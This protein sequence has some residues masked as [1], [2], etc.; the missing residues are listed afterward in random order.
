MSANAAVRR[1]H[2]DWLS[3]LQR[4]GPFL[5]VPVLVRTWPAGLD[6]VPR[7]LMDELR[8][9]FEEWREDPAARHQ[10]WITFVLEELLDWDGR[11]VQGPDLPARL[12]LPVPERDQVLR[13]DFGFRGEG[14][15]YLLLGTVHPPGTNLAVRLPGER[16][17]A[18]PTDRLALLL[19][20]HRVPLGLATD[21]RWWA[22]VWAAPETT[23]VAIWD[24]ALWLEE[25]D[26]LAAFRCLLERRRF[27]GVPEAQTLPRLL[28][29]GLEAQEEITETLGRQVRQAV[30][31]LV[32]AIGRAG[33]E[34]GPARELL[35]EISAQEIYRA[36]VTVMMRLVFLLFAEERLLLPADDDLYR[37]SYSAGQLVDELRAA[38]NDA[39]S[40]DVLEHRTTAWHRLLS[41]F[42]AVHRG[43]AH[44]RLRIPAYGGGVFDPDRYPWLEGRRSAE[45]PPAGA[46]VLPIDDRT[47]LHALEA[48]QFVTVGGERRRLTFRTLDVEQIGYVYEGLLGYDAVRAPEPVAGLI[49]R[50]GEEPEV[51]VRELEARGSDPVWLAEVTGLSQGRIARALALAEADPHRTELLL[52]A[53]CAGD[54]GL[55]ARLRP[56]AGLLRQ[57]LR[58]LPVVVPAGGLYVTASRRRRQSG[59]HYTPRELAERVV[60]GALEPLVYAPGP[61]E[62]KDRSAWRLRPSREILGLR[63]VD[64]AM[65]SGAFLVAAC[66][67]L[68]DR[69]VE[70]WTVEGN[71]LARRPAGTE[72]LDPESDP[73]VIEARRRVIERCLYGGDINEMAVEMAKLS[74]WL[75]SLSRE[76][77]FSFLDDRLVCGD[78]LLGL[79]SLEQLRTL[80]LDPARA[81]RRAGGMSESGFDLWGAVSRALGEAEGI[82]RE[83]AE[84]PLRDVR[85]AAY[86]ARLLAQAEATERPLA[87]IADAMVGAALACGEEAER[88]L[89]EVAA[90]AARALREADPGERERRLRAMA[91][92]AAARLEAGRPEGAFPRRPTHWPLVFPEVFER[93]GF[94]AVVGNP[95]FLGG[96][97][98]TGAFGVP[99]RE[100]LVRWV[101]RGK[102]GSADLVAYFLLV[103]HAILSPNGQAGLIATN[104]LAQGDTREVGLDR[105]VAD[106]V[107]I[108]AA[109][110]SAKWPT[111]SAN[112]E[113]AVL[114]SSRREPAPEAE[115]LLDGRPVSGITPSLEAAGR[116]TG[117]P[118]RLKANQGIAF[119]GSIVLGMGFTMSPEEAERLIERDPRNRGVLFPYLNGEDLNSRPDCSPSRWVI[120]FRDWPLERAEQYHDCIE[121][122]RRLV[123][124]ERERNRYSKSAK[125]R[126]WQFER[127][128]PELHAAIEGMD[129]VLAIARVSKTVLPVFVPTGIVVSEDTVVFA[130]HDDAH[131]TLL[132]S[133]FHYWWAIRHASTMRT[134]L[135]YTPSD[136]FETFP[137]PVMTAR[138]EAAGERLDGL[139][140]PLMLD[141]QLGLTALYNLVHDPSVHDPDVERLRE[142]HVEVD[143]ATAE[144]YGWDDLSLGHGFHPTDRGTRFTV[145]EAARAELLDRL[146]ELN[147]RRHAEEVDRD[148]VAPD[149]RGRRRTRQAALRLEA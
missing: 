138:M 84:H 125:E 110:K 18:S 6:P 72:G 30:E 80:H 108:R 87:M 20:A 50:P 137:Q 62:T 41:L 144:A 22:L 74:L 5:T 98:L 64:V 145:S 56:F 79:T 107:T 47:V 103:A 27:L 3:L 17:A 124:P 35:A 32:E 57:D 43:L 28:E 143:L 113:Y 130:Y 31:M 36:A 42:R 105:L 37:R 21:G 119:Q 94:D 58:G 139:R 14:D 114:W 25:R 89:L 102:R 99:Y 133:A 76:R 24:G 49:G 134:D 127:V 2:E 53:A 88:E 140:R 141:R 46:P 4:T 73:V 54:E 109:V 128:R 66:R 96:Q 123:K 13:P 131:L 126:W 97:K 93:G 85:D 101:G 51:T 11:L 147:H 67:Y 129:R 10:A 82:R 146:L 39:G 148:L 71:P 26:S 135:R 19:R 149:G 132:S 115:R 34:H 7:E 40:E 38:A 81:R 8:P 69:V 116:I 122:V 68:A 55:V 45:E 1:R 9:R 111:R 91:Q 77:P 117:N 61:L 78:S 33:A 15:A 136:V 29:A 106:G 59:T 112:L 63:V 100:F 118:F 16:W 95:P 92:L 12:A 75:V 52:R 104:T 44:D 142:L 23:S 121:I 65:G 86:K 120:N 90:E 48:V 83:L 70:A 60:T